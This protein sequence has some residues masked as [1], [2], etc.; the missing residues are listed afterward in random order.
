MAEATPNYRKK[1]AI[2]CVL[3]FVCIVAAFLADRAFITVAAILAA[4][5]ICYLA[6]KMQPEPPPEEHHH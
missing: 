6:A 3:V 4:C 1:Q 2:L 5:G